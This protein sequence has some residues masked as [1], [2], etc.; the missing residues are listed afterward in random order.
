MAIIG[1]AMSSSGLDSTNALRMRRSSS[2]PSQPSATP[3]PMIPP[4]EAPP[5]KSMGTPAS[6]RART[7]P[8][9]AKARAPA[10][11]Q[12]QPHRLSDQHPAQAR[13][14]GAVAL[15]DVEQPVGRPRLQP[16]L[17]PLRPRPVRR[18]QQDQVDQALL[19]QRLGCIDL[20]L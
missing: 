16:G 18:L 8:M 12:H 14:V 7:A 17:R 15:A 13:D 6:R 4:I 20:R 19:Q 2:S 1:R 11:R 3:A 10:A 9:W 5:T